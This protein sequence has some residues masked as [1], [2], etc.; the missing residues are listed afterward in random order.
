MKNKKNKFIKIRVDEK[1][2]NDFDYICKAY[3]LN[4]SDLIRN[5]IIMECLKYGKN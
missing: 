3:Y 4:K 1:L 2:A 5:L